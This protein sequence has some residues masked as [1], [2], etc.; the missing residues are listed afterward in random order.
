[1]RRPSVHG[2]GEWSRRAIPLS[3][4]RRSCCPTAPAPV[5]SGGGRCGTGRCSLSE[6]NTQGFLGRFE[7]IGRDGFPRLEPFHL[8]EARDVQEHASSHD[9]MG[10]GRDAHGR[11]AAHVF[12][13]D[14]VERAFFVV[15]PPAPLVAYGLEERVEL[16]GGDASGF[17]GHD[18][19]PLSRGARLSHSH[20]LSHFQTP[21]QRAAQGTNSFTATRPL[22]FKRKIT[23]PVMSSGSIHRPGSAGGPRR[24]DD[25]RGRGYVD[26]VPSSLLDH[27]L[28]RRLAQEE[29]RFQVHVHVRVELLFGDLEERRGEMHAVDLLFR[30]CDSNHPA[31]LAREGKGDVSP[32]T[33]SRARHHGGPSFQVYTSVLLA[34][35]FG[36]CVNI[37]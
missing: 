16:S 21:S 1:M 6:P 36:F 33:S 2:A 11:G 5:V 4:P 3:P 32:D 14:V 12:R 30:S 35:P 25:A 18:G 10:I 19:Y 8:P 37:S 17:T 23:H 24:Y 31:P 26:D 27:H 9:A 15:G 13:P 29:G 22:Y 34:R 28:D 7:L 20:P